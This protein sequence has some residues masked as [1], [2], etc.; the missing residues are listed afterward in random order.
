MTN[1]IP[2]PIAISEYLHTSFTPDCDYVDGIVE[3]RNVGGVEHA[4]ARRALLAWIGQRGREWGVRAEPEVRVQTS[5]SHVRV[6]DVALIADGEPGGQ[7]I[8][9]PPVAVIEILSSED[10]IQHATE[11]L[12]DY[13]RMGVKSVWVVDPAARKGFDA[14]G[15]DWVESERFTAPESPIAVDPA[16]IF[17]EMDQGSAR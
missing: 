5:A 6:A 15:A 13:R 8:E 4:A 17:A 12:E 14:S 1:S 10:N 16:A 7:A 9:K 2:P 11:R 3:T